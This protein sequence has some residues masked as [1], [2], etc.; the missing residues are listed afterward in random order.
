MPNELEDGDWDLLLR[1]IKDGKCTPFLGAGVCAEKIPVYSQI[2]EEWVKKYDYPMED[3]YDLTRVAQFVAVAKDHMTPKEE[4]CSK[5]KEKLKE[6]A[7]GYFDN[8]DEPHRVLADLPLSIYIT[9]NYDDFMVQALKSRGKTPIQ[10]YCRW[11][12]CIMQSERT[13]S[14]YVPTPEKPL[15]FHLHDNWVNNITFSPDGKCIA[16]ASWDKKAHLWSVDTGE[17]IF[18]LSHNGSV[19][20]VVFSPDGKYIATASADN[21]AR[22]WDAATGKQIFVLKHEDVFQLL[23]GLSR[24]VAGCR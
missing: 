3:S 19:N 15:V 8:P 23:Q 11:N 16:T 21:T 7:P 5:I 2:A 24:L 17:E 12:K 13:S 22:V 18:V 6:V 20:D 10:E 1:R 9:T 4:M 14:D